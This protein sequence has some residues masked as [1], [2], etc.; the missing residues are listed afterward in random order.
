V[1]SL[2]RESGGFPKTTA[3]VGGV[4]FLLLG[5][6]ALVAPASFF[7]SIAVFEPYNSHF[8]QD[9]GAFQIGL[10]ATLVL[11][12]FLTSDAL[13]AALI[14]VGTGAIAHVASHLASLDSG[15]NPALD[16]PVLSVLGVLL[17]VAGG[18]RWRHIRKGS[19]G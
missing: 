9:L 12:A 14:G 10:G 7:D 19:G 3:A 6:W 17:V 4:V 13:V 8:V 11:A 5:L 16:V 2:S 18:V 15:G 1:S